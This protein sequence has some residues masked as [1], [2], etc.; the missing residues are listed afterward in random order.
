MKVYNEYLAVTVEGIF[1]LSG[2]STDIMNMK[3]SIDLGQDVDINL[4]SDPH[5]N[6][7]VVIYGNSH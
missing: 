2:N 6:Y 3:K 4:V 5:G 7:F 1:R